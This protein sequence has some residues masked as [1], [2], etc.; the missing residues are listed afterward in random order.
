LGLALPRLTDPLVRGRAAGLL[1]GAL[2]ARQQHE[3]A[4]DVL[5]GAVADLQSLDGAGRELWWHLQAQLVIVGYGRPSTIPTARSWARR[6]REFGLPGDTP[7]QRAVLL[8][9]AVPAMMGEADAAAVND[10]LDRGLRGEL[11][12]DARAE[13]ALAL[14]GLGYALTDRLGD[15]DMRFEQMSELAGRCGSAR[16]SAQALAGLLGVRL[17]RGEQVPLS[18][19]L[20]H[21]G[22]DSAELADLTARLSFV[23]TAVTSLVER[24]EPDAAVELLTR[25]A[26][27][28]A[29]D[30]VMWGAVILSSCRVQAELGNLTGA[31]AMLLAVGN[32]GAAEGLDNPAAAPWRT[33]AALIHVALGQREEAGRLA[34]EGL[35]AA[36]RW[37]TPRVIGAALSCRG[38]VT[39]G[40][41]GR[42]LL[43]E[44]VT[45]L[46]TSPARLELA[47]ALHEW[48]RA[49]LRA[50]ER[51]D[52]LSVLSEALEQAEECGSRLLAGRIR[53]E[54]LSAG[55]RPGPV[56]PAPP[57]QSIIEY[58]VASLRAAGRTDRQIAQ[59]LLLSPDVVA[60][61]GR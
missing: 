35:E 8:A 12:T 40:A 50:G 34:A 59:N 32:H 58:R 26:D 48:G 19:R 15:A 37:G 31:L 23:T 46:R 16:M 24:G 9:L 7:G 33:E 41:E 17:R 25:H 57:S 39:G 55:V 3:R 56:P 28:A 13:N 10:L 43:A 4:M 21:T 44:A 42:A 1:A 2:F 36:Y 38:V 20:G 52:G 5:E 30:S 47:R 60:A 45:V 53:A 61:I 11:M 22:P 49:L 27:G 14:A 6:L 54:L 29:E 51:G 18:A